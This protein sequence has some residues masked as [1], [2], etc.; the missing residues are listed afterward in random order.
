MLQSLHIKNYALIKE[1]E[2]TPSSKL[3]IITGETGAG[4]SIVLGAMGLLLGNRVDTKVLFDFS[5]KCMVEGVFDLS[6]YRLKK[7]FEKE[8]LNY[9]NECVIRREISPNGKSRAFINDTPATLNTLK[10]IGQYLVD[11]HSQHDSLQLNDNNY[12]L[13]VLDAY[14][15]HT[16]LMDV[17]VRDFEKYSII[18][19]KL[20]ALKQLASKQNEN[21]EYKNFILKE[22]EEINLEEIDQ[23]ILEKELNILEHAED[24]KLK[25]SQLTQIL[26]SS[27]YAVLTQIHKMIQSVK[28][29]SSFAASIKEIENRL[30]SSSIELGDILNEIRKEEEQIDHSPE[31]AYEMKERLD[32]IYR[33]QKKHNSH[34]I[35]ELITLRD[36]LAKELDTTVNIDSKI[37]ELQKVFDQAKENMYKSGQKLSESRKLNALNFAHEIEK[38]IKKIG[39]ENGTLEIIVSLSE[40]PKPNGLDHVEFMFSANKGIRPQELK[41]VASGGEFSR[42]TF[43]LKYLIADKTSLPTIIFDEIDTGVSGHIAL[44]MIAMMKKIANNHQVISIS[45]LP[46]FAAGGDTHY[47]VYKDHS[48]ERSISKIKKLHGEER[49]IEIAKMIAGKNPGNSAIESAKEL[50]KIY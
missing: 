10:N 25:L 3:N 8:D 14:A 24:I 42:L 43:A 17:Y 6:A 47:Y 18:Y 31:K 48:M 1:L 32:A 45:H 26:D 49:I 16:E 44:Q 2:I 36:E 5:S 39:I 37:E 41:E 13:N 19:K 11:I 29:V 30:Q 33:L 12:Q 22:L 46:Q 27:E 40:I 23:K 15:S 20:K 50:L 21:I 34:T 28:S 38:I 9:E 7:F 35:E 4:K